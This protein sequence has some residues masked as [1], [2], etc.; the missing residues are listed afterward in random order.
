[1]P[2]Q[3]SGQIAFLYK[4]YNPDTH[5]ARCNLSIADSIASVGA[6]LSRPPPIHRPFT[7]VSINV[8]FPACHPE[9]SEGSHGLGNEILR[10]AQNDKLTS[11]KLMTYATYN[12]VCENKV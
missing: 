6:D 5:M 8:I 11:D 7:L 10:F 1:M 3:L 2:A 12:H 4:T 9:R